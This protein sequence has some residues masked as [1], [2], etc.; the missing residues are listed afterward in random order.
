MGEILVLA[1]HRQGVV[2]D[3][4]FEMLGAGRALAASRGAQLT[5]LLLGQ[6]LG[7]LANALSAHADVVEVVEDARLAQ[8]SSDAYQ[9]VLARVIRERTPLVCLIGHTAYGMELAPSLATELGVPLIADA[10]CVELEE[11][12]IR[13]ERPVYGG[14]V[15]AR[16]RSKGP[17]AIVTMQAGAFAAADE[18]A[19]AGQIV[20]SD[21]LLSGEQTRKRFVGFVEAVL[22]DVDIA[23]SDIVV[24]VGRGIGD[25]KNLPLVEALARALGGVLSCSRPVVDKKWLPKTR[26]VGISGKTVSPKLYLAVGISGA[27]QHLSGIKSST[28]I[29]AVNKDPKA[30]I[31]RVADYGI[32][33]DLFTVVPALT[34]RIAKAKSGK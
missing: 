33:G 32:V 6:G 24:S 21:A 8:F 5:A 23:Q 13:A 10:T 17:A 18:R 4:T 26:Q 14:K 30:P 19:T 28:T 31:F 27:F 7:E 29:V 2:R 3:I 20:H 11:G 22:G 12:L 34:E 15:R 16:V 9:E 1:E 25:P